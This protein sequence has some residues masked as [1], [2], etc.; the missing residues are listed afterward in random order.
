MASCRRNGGEVS[1]AGHKHPEVLLPDWS[2]R[3]MVGAM[4]GLGL[5]E[6]HGSGMCCNTLHALLAEY[7]QTVML[8]Y[9]G[10]LLMCPQA[11]RKVTESVGSVVQGR[12]AWN[13]I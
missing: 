6:F 1:S 12:E 4:W 9:T 13:Q 3:L 2:C 11:R 7:N 5:E 8:A 10:V